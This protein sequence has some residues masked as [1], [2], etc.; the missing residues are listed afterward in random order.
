MTP[1]D[2]H[3][4]AFKTHHDHFQ[5]RVMPFGLTNAPAIFQCLMNHIFAPFMR[6]FVLVFMDDILI[7]SRTLED[8]DSHLEQVFQ[9]L[10][11]HKLFVKFSKCDFAQPPIEYLDYII[12]NAG[13]ST[14]PTKT[15]AMLNWPTPT[16][17]TKIRDFLG[18]TGYYRKFIRHYGIMAKPITSILKQKSFS[19]PAEA[20]SAFKTLK[21][22][23][24]SAPVLSLPDFAEPFEIETDACDTGVGAVLSQ[25]GH[26]I[27]FLSKALSRAN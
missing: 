17:F 1:Q 3:K 24:C 25:H 22:I 21:S 26:P 4:T 12:S 6:R 5:F 18:L 23:M 7:Y 15:E 14:D 10:L 9:V 27:A 2:E 13:I 8:H 11:Q 20:E 19:W 16:S